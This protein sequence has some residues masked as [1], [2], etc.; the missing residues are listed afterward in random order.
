MQSTRFIAAAI[1]AV[2]ITAGI[3]RADAWVYGRE[4][5]APQGNPTGLG[6]RPCSK[7]HDAWH[8]KIPHN[9]QITLEFY[10]PAAAMLIRPC[11]YR[12]VNSGNESHDVWQVEEIKRRGYQCQVRKMSSNSFEVFKRP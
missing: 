5:L 1:A 8:C 7:A 12:L 11:F 3:A 6:G 2:V 4:G 9:S 10:R